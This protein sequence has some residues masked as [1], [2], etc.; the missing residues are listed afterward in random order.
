MLFRSAL[1]INAA[2]TFTADTWYHIAIVRNG[3]TF[4]VY[5]NGTS[6]G[7]G[8]TSQAISQDNFKFAANSTTGQSGW[9]WWD[10]LRVSDTA[11]YT[12]NFTAPTAP[13]QN[14]ANTLMLLHMDGTDASTDF[15][16]DNGYFSQSIESLSVATVDYSGTTDNY[17]NQNVRS[18]L[19]TISKQR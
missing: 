14:D 18:K 12:S 17:S 15:R 13:F 11:R 9:G 3:S 4:T 2:F 19:E 1:N 5:I 10:E 16:D 6:Y 8:T 7:T